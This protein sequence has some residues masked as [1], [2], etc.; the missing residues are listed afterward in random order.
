MLTRHALKVPTGGK[1]NAGASGINPPAGAV[2]AFSN[3]SP[4]NSSTQ[5]PK[6]PLLSYVA[7]GITRSNVVS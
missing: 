7:C 6:S 4:S 2:S 1:K 3:L 5:H